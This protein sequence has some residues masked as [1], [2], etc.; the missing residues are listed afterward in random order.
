MEAIRKQRRGQE[1]LHDLQPG[2]CLVSTHTLSLHSGESTWLAPAGT[3]PP[4]TWGPSRLTPSVTA[5]PPTGRP[6]S[7][8]RIPP[9]RPCSPSPAPTGEG[10]LLPPLPQ[11]RERLRV[12]LQGALPP[13][14]WVMPEDLSGLCGF[15]PTDLDWEAQGSV[16]RALQRRA[17][18]PGQRG[19]RSPQGQMPPQ[20]AACV[21]FAKGVGIR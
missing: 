3:Q 1:T 7:L 19:L 10:A 16:D 12:S 8:P 4:L 15:H 9:S 14:S 18:R 13:T 11:L 17:R 21:G 2:P 5:L 20:S 6:Q